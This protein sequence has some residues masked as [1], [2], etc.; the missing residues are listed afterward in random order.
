MQYILHRLLSV[1]MLHVFYVC[2]ITFII[3]QSITLTSDE[4]CARLI[5]AALISTIIYVTENTPL[6]SSHFIYM[7]LNLI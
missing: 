3:Q 7:S 1:L 6:T 4:A 2:F 5:Q